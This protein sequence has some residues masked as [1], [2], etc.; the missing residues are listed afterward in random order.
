MS[1][2]GPVA[3]GARPPCGAG[4]CNL[5]RQ[6][7]QSIRLLPDAGHVV[8]DHTATMLEFLTSEPAVA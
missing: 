2:P 6:T 8:R 5:R 7:Y 3:P 4:Y 1:G